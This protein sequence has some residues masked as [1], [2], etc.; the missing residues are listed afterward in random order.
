MNEAVARDILE[1]MRNRREERVAIL[2]DQARLMRER[3][4]DYEGTKRSR[5]AKMAEDFDLDAA[6][7]AR[8]IEAIDWFLEGDEHG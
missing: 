1:S 4:H 2:R 6:R 3:L 7:M 5:C 8:T